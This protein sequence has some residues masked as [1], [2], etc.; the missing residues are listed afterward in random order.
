[1]IHT[2]P[3]ATPILSK[4]PPG[5]RQLPDNFVFTNEINQEIERFRCESSLAQVLNDIAI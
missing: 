1:M 5:Q 4:T 3:S 2:V